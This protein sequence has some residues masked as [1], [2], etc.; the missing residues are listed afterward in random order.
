MR[1]WIRPIPPGD[2]AVDRVL[3][4]AAQSGVAW[5][6]EPSVADGADYVEID[7]LPENRALGNHVLRN[8]TSRYRVRLCDSQ[9]QADAIVGVDPDEASHIGALATRTLASG[10]IGALWC[11]PIE[12]EEP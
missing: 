3:L 8:W 12:V 11:M 7:E 9:A 5:P 1:L 10:K 6:D 2:T 4:F